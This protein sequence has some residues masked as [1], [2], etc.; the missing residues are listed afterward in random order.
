M[1]GELEYQIRAPINK[2]PEH[3]CSQFLV[4]TNLPA[5]KSWRLSELLKRSSGMFHP[6]E[7]GWWFGT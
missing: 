4:E 5:P 3:T 7:T 6:N 2:D 1:Q